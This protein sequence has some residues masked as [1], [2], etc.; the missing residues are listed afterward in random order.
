MSTEP[1]IL[2]QHKCLFP[3]WMEHRWNVWIRLSKY[4]STNS[5]GN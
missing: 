4:P 3:L 5:H 1:T 2:N